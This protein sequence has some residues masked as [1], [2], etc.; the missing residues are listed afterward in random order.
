MTF[1]D[2]LEYAKAGY[3]I[4]HN[5]TA[6]DD[7]IYVDYTAHKIRPYLVSDSTY[8]KHMP[9][10]VTDRDLFADDWEISDYG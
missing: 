9:Y 7:V 10:H 1:G 5:G 6:C 8:E 3:R 4:F 2:A